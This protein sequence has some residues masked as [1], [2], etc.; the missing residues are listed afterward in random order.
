MTFLPLN[1]VGL[2]YIAH[3]HIGFHTETSLV[4]NFLGDF[5]KGNSLQHLPA[6]LANGVRL[7]RKV[8]QFTDKHP[9]IVH[10]RSK[11]PPS[12]RRMAGVV[13]D[14]TF[15]HYLLQH[16]SQFC[17]RSP[18]DV[19]DMFYRQ[20]ADTQAIDHPRFA[21]LSQSLQQHRWLSDYAHQ[22][23]CLQVFSSIER[24]LRHKI[25]FADEA[26]AFMQ[27]NSTLLSE[28]FLQFY[29]QLLEYA[30]TCLPDSQ[31]G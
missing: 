2:N 13:I 16:W 25:C 21:Q 27:H 3:I 29:P 12:L 17:A 7:H 26:Y 8:D 22:Q 6:E 9:A 10:L 30:Q 31:S 15:D 28:H 11:F 5:V 19:L 1:G 14:V 20:L 24:R 18:H 4:G 23:T